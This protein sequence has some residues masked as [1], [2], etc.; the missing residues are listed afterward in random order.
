MPARHEYSHSL[1]EASTHV[2]DCNEDVWAPKVGWDSRLRGQPPVAARVALRQPARKRGRI[3]VAHE[4]RSLVVLD[5]EAHP[6]ALR[7]MRRIKGFVL[8]VRDLGRCDLKVARDADTVVWVLVL[9]RRRL[10]RL[11]NKACTQ[12]QKV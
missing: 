6:P 3:L 2:S 9:R 1:Y 5:R 4:H 8:H 10:F 11:A 7:P 12:D